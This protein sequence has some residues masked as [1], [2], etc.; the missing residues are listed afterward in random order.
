[1]FFARKEK[2]RGTVFFFLGVILVFL[3][4]PFFGVVIELFGFIDLFGYL[5]A[6]RRC[7]FNLFSARDFMPVVISF[8]RRM[9]IVSFWRFGRDVLN[10][11]I[12]WKYFKH[13]RH[14]SNSRQTPWISTQ[15]SSVKHFLYQ[16]LASMEH[17]II[18]QNLSVADSFMS[19]CKK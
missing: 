11:H 19:R 10:F 14:I 1:M 16:I 9:P 7:H 2:L 12:D 17:I 15:A 5:F 3:K 4:W 13:A 6:Y 18:I 8:L